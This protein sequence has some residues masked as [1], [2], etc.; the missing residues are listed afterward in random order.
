MSVFLPKDLDN[1]AIPAVR[2]KDGAAHQIAATATAARNTTAFDAE[3]RIVSVFASGPVFIKFGD[4]TVTATATDHYFP[5]GI[6]YDFAI[7][8]EKV[9]HYTHLSVLRADIDCTVYISEKE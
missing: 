2:L 3:T 1:A 4:A 5:E 9:P 8:G 6:Y 7:G